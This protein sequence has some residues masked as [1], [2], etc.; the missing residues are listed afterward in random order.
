[1]EMFLKIYK[2][3]GPDGPQI[4]VAAFETLE[5]A[6]KLVH[7]MCSIARLHLQ[8]AEKHDW[9]VLKVE[10]VAPVSKATP[11]KKIVKEVIDTGLTIKSSI[12]KKNVS[13]EFIWDPCKVAQTKPTEKIDTAEKFFGKY[14]LLQS[15]TKACIFRVLLTIPKVVCCIPGIN[16]EEIIKNLDENFELYPV[17]SVDLTENLLS[18]PTLE[19]LKLMDRCL[20]E[21]FSWS[22]SKQ[23]SKYWLGIHGQIYKAISEF[24]KDSIDE[25]L[26]IAEDLVSVPDA[27]TPQTPSITSKEFMLVYKNLSKLQKKFLIRSYCAYI[28]GGKEKYGIA[29]EELNTNLYITMKGEDNYS[30]PTDCFTNFK[31]LSEIEQLKVIREYIEVSMVWHDTLPGLEYWSGIH[32]KLYKVIKKLEQE[33][34]EMEIVSASS[35]ETKEENLSLEEFKK[36]HS[37]AYSVSNTHRVSLLRTCFGYFT[38]TPPFTLELVMEVNKNLLEILKSDTHL[39]SI[40]LYSDLE[41]LSQKAKAKL[42]TSLLSNGFIWADTLQ[43]HDHWS[44]IMGKL[45]QIKYKE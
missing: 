12:S 16:S 43:G 11:K 14:S 39:F 18:L 25:D 45:L 34:K 28:V 42:A 19:K 22:N 24:P 10:Q 33:K 7:P 31:T 44:N 20:S 40:E 36:K 15:N 38:N 27:P 9:Q 23:G 13:E 2:V 41:K 37:N 21:A 6:T 5:T 29:W 26:V 8:F 17:L 4:Q 35:S 3:P 32:D 1:M 30:L